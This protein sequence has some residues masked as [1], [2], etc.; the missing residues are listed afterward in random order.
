M[1]SSCCYRLHKHSQILTAYQYDAAMAKEI[2]DEIK[3]YLYD[4]KY[5]TT[6]QEDFGP[7]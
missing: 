4:K 5:N 3:A 7:F 2:Q 6:F 1:A